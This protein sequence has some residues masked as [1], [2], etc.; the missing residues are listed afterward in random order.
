MRV[1][2]G[3]P[4]EQLSAQS[5]MT[6]ACVSFNLQNQEW[7]NQKHE[8][9]VPF[10]RTELLLRILHHALQRMESFL[11]SVQQLRNKQYTHGT[12]LL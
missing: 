1:L 9:H 3:P 11:T 12:F 6:S 2:Q 7:S 8:F 4:T 5:I 10:G